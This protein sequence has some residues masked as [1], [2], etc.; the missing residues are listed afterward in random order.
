M[1][2]VEP[3]HSIPLFLGRVA[4]DACDVVLQYFEPAATVQSGQYVRNQRTGVLPSRL[5]TTGSSFAVQ[6]AV[7][8]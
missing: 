6:V 7:I 2:G 3:K 8:Y 4:N 1:P 5:Y